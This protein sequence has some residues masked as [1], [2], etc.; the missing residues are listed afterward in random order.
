M[1]TWLDVLSEK[2]NPGA[3]KNC[4]GFAFPHEKTAYKIMRVAPRV[5]DSA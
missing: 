4:V 2:R 5:A 3:S 1:V